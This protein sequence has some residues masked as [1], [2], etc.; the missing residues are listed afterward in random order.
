MGM[1]IL[2]PKLKL[3]VVLCDP[4]KQQYS[5]LRPVFITHNLWVI[6]WVIIYESKYKTHRWKPGDRMQERRAKD[7]AKKGKNL[8]DCGACLQTDFKAVSHKLWLIII[9][10]LNSASTHLKLYSRHFGIGLHIWKVAKM[11]VLFGI[12]WWIHGERFSETKVRATQ[13]IM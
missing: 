3:I 5:Q 9:D 10:L 6:S 4:I 11:V 12:V 1:K 8:K 13:T 2:N 7:Y